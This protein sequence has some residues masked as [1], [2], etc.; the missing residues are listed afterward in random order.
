MKFLDRIHARTVRVKLLAV[1]VSL[2]IPSVILTVLFV[3]SQQADVSFAQKEIDGLNYLEP[4]L[5]VIETVPAHRGT[6]NGYLRGGP[7]EKAYFRPLALDYRAKVEA[8]IAAVDKVDAEYGDEFETTPMWTAFKKNWAALRDGVEAL[9]A[10]E[11]FARH[12]AL[13]TELVAIQRRVSDRSN[14][15]LDPISA[16]YYLQDTQAV[17][18]PFMNEFVGQARGFSNGL[19]TAKSMTP[20]EQRQLIRLIG[21]VEAAQLLVDQNFAAIAEADPTQGARLKPE[22]DA[23]AGKLTSFLTLLREQMAGIDMPGGNQPAD[24]DV[25]PEQVW[26]QGTDAIEAYFRLGN[27][28]VP[29]LQT[30]LEDRRAAEATS[31]WLG[32]TLLTAGLILVI[33]LVVI[34]SR[35]IIRQTGAITETMSAVESGNLSAR[36]VIVTRD[37]LGGLAGSVNSMLDTTLKLVQSR[38]ERDALQSS[39]IK[40]LDEVSVVADGDL[41]TE[42]EVTADALGSVADA[43]NYM[44]TQL[45]DVIGNVTDS[46]LQVSASANQIQATA[47]H[48]AGASQ[49]QAEQ[50]LSASAA[51]DEM[52]VS[53][54]QVSEKAVNSASVAQHAADNAR[55][56]N[57]A[58]RE[59]IA[60]MGRIRE[61]VQETAK[62]IKRLGESSQEIGQIVEL[63]D[64]IADRTSIL[65]LNASIQAANAGEAGR[66]F[67]VVAEQ[68]ERLAVSSTEATRKIA[69][70]IK[71]IQSETTEAV[72]AMDQGIQ[73]VVSGSTLANQAGHSL[74]QIQAESDKLAE[75]IRSISMAADQQAR[76]SE[77]LARSMGSIA[78]ITQETA[79]GTQDASQSMGHL[80]MLADELRKSVS[81]FKLPHRAAPVIAQTAAPR[82]VNGNGHAKPTRVGPPKVPASR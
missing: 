27:Q 55:Q 39:I 48:L 2:A 23:A 64:D 21:E 41:T 77:D 57:K 44:I 78:E 4:L 26:K 81:S 29:P 20:A 60:G 25:P 43:F 33:G 58:V 1:A 17:R 14:L 49:S 18:I 69:G 5:E 7:A 19:A 46:T 71:S 59:T 40:L 68:V 24:L 79:G 52:A 72:A 36:S 54:R 22:A 30:M 28:L 47:E 35:G 75:L 63:I 82:D 62:R 56:G 73:E 76:G 11:A 31:M 6:M 12:T 3:R 67:A 9:P 15:A 16:S 8:A 32:A 65:A 53:V 61:Q 80:A 13:I 38:E 51:I 37:E 34:V 50:I 74:E 66:G 70:L 45:R 42:A 10:A